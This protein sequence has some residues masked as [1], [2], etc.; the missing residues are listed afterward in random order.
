M[1]ARHITSDARYRTPF[2][3]AP[4]GGAV[5]LSIDVWDEPEATAQLRIW[6]DERGEILLPMTGEWEDD[7][8]HF[9]AHFTPSEPEV[10]WYSFLITAADGAVWR[11][12]AA[13]EHGCGEGAF[14]Y[15]EP[16]SFQITV[17]QRQR[18]VMPEWFKGGIAYQI[19]PD[20]FARGDD[21][22][23]RVHDSLDAPRKGPDRVLVDDWGR[24][25]R[26][27][28]NPDGSV[29]SWDFYGGTL[30]GVREK[31]PYLQSMGVSVIYLNPIFEAAS[32]H[33]YDTA[34]FLRIDPMLG[35]EK[36]FSRLC[37][38]AGERGISIIL[39][40]VFNH[41][42]RDSR[43]FDFFGNY[44]GEGAYQSPHSR[45]RSWF[46]FNDDGTYQ[47]WWGVGDLPD[48]NQ[49]NPEYRELICGHDGVIRK[50]LRLGARGWR[51]DVADELSDDFI[52]D[53]KSAALAEKSDALLIGEVWEDASNKTAYG[54]L[55]KYF[56]GAELDSTMNYPLRHAL[57]DFL[58]NKAGAP[59]F[60]STLRS[61]QENYPRENFYSTL[62]MLGSHDR[63][64]LLTILGDAPAQ[65]QMSDDEKYRFRLDEGHRSLAISRLWCAALLQM[66]LP[67][68]PC[69]YYGDEAGL[70]GYS[71]P[72]C[73]AAFPWGHEDADCK[74]I[75]RNA[76]A[77]RKSLPVFVDGD[78]E[79][80][81]IGDDVFGFWRRDDESSV[82]V[83]VNAS[84]KKSHT[85]SVPVA[86]PCV[87]DVV[88]GNVP[89]VG[90][91]GAKVFLWPLGTSVLYF[92]EEQ[93][94]QQSMPHGMGVLAHI[95]SVPNPDKPGRHGTLGEPTRRFID[96]LA[97][98]KQHYWQVL[99]ANPT[100]SFGSPYAGLSAFAGNRELMWGIENGITSFRAD[101]EETPSFRRF[102]EKNERWLM[103][104][105]T[106]LAI[107]KQE[108]GAPWQE[109][110][111]RYREWSPQL[112]AREELR[113]EVRRVCAT[114]YE[115]QRQ[116]DE[117]RRYA[118][119]RGIQL[120]GDM[121]MYVSADSADVWAERKIF[122]LGPDGTPALRAGCPPDSFSADGQ[123]CG[124]PTYRWDVLR[125]TGY[126]WWMRRF[127]RAFELYDYVRLD[128]FLGFSSYYTI[129]EGKTALEG[130]W[131][132]GP[133]LDLFREARRR[134]G[135][136][137]FIAED[138][139]TVT[140]AV[141]ALL[142][143]TGFPGMDV[144]QFADEDV[145]RG[146][147]PK[148][149]KMAYTSTHDTQTLLGWCESRFGGGAVED[150]LGREGLSYSR[151]EE[152]RELAERLRAAT[153]AT[154]AN[155]AIVSL[156]DVLMLDDSARMNV[157]GVATG[158]WSWQADLADVEQSQGLLRQLAEESGRA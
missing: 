25:P 115:F 100:D 146:F 81:A 129:P 141:R 33:R 42:G 27:D 134:F 15:G 21:W 75:Y 3:A 103:P 117:M 145:R 14:A 128:H 62:N 63:I 32:N 43:Y 157:P 4:A 113:G 28:R 126:D 1:R 91:D 143:A 112:A 5:V 114:Q 107:R 101:F 142:A 55:R 133:G 119:E 50:W 35:D 59:K 154:N 77:I 13:C 53:I 70:E 123:L 89:E 47:S 34:D 108:G 36:S 52:A 83:L 44:G 57:E 99:P 136:L 69:V 78:F 118:N 149:G 6:I 90:D 17:Y 150:G 120:I 152:M 76:I 72:Y 73:R 155:V 74:T 82:C 158:N 30:E 84:L 147:H 29:R 127:E 2:G 51:L 79:P 18:T 148:P 106:F 9:S 66:T 137:P 122:E 56:Q 151:V 19:F 138:L 125:D 40:G 39:D 67:G 85:V 65:A 87:D 61:L 156:Q 139:G 105:A 124:N 46:K 64:R 110:P 135:D 11:Y 48:F 98:G 45:Y 10:I 144:I 96:Y 116:W 131:N 88:T 58:T 38:D 22:E 111:K 26:Y 130:A 31:L 8:L 60:V 23:G 132:F 86:G 49:D 94:L 109:W 20:R 41:C 12:G 80:F 140:P 104:Y 153:L 93:R 68:V 71:D 95:T 92:H 16:P 7:H 121:P 37:H 97:A 102:M 54:K 24:Y